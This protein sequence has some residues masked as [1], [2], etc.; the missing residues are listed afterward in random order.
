MTSLIRQLNQSRTDLARTL[1]DGNARLDQLRT[2]RAESQERIDR[3][4]TLEALRGTRVV[5]PRQTA[6][7]FGRLLDSD[8]GFGAAIAF[9]I[10]SAQADFADLVDSR[11]QDASNQLQELRVRERDAA[12]DQQVAFNQQQTINRAESDAARLQ[13]DDARADLER[14]D[15]I[16][17]QETANNQSQQRIDISRDQLEETR[18]SNRISRERARSEDQDRNLDR[19]IALSDRIAQIQ[20]DIDTLT[21]NVSEEAKVLEREAVK[22]VLEN[23]DNASES[24]LVENIFGGGNQ[25]SKNRAVNARILVENGDEFLRTIKSF[26]RQNSKEVLADV[27][28]GK[29]DQSLSDISAIIAN[30][31]VIDPDDTSG[32]ARSFR[33]QKATLAILKARISDEVNSDSGDTQLINGL[34]ERE[35]LLLGALERTRQKAEAL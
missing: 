34:R 18:E 11:I 35:A 20:S 24:T 32:I 17:Q 6:N 10:T 4:S 29:L 31:E 14:A 26:K 5:N 22:S 33:D 1:R 9:G 19:T 15:R 12:A 3:E 2:E 23:F 13:V 7:N 21:P 8:G 30:R 16:L 25:D 28:N 27:L